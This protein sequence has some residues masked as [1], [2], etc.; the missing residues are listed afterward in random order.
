[1]KTHY[2]TLG[3][4][5]SASQREIRRAYLRQIVKYHP[6]RNP[7]PK[8][9]RIAAAL[10][11]AYETL[12]DAETRDAYDRKLRGDERQGLSR[13]S[14]PTPRAR[15]RKPWIAVTLRTA[16]LLCFAYLGVVMLLHFLG[17]L[18]TPTGSSLASEAVPAKSPVNAIDKTG[19]QKR[20]SQPQT[21]TPLQKPLDTDGRSELKV[22]NVT[23]A[24]A[25]VYLVELNSHRIARSFYLR[26]GDRFTERNIAPGT[27]RLAF[28]TGRDWDAKAERFDRDA[29]AGP[30][31]G[32]L[33]FAEGQLRADKT[34]GSSRYE[35]R[36]KLDGSWIED[37]SRAS[38]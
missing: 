23:G 37:E 7:D 21:G 1:M 31:A 20:A 27:Y 34:K 9:V 16:V 12:S 32:P 33:G 10:N 5:Q 3:V 8:A 4:P 24:D 19:P 11:E 28:V 38:E 18:R 35:V 13:V 15:A 14:V 6:D 2:E 25:V 30:S 29:H 17:A 36:L 22:D 26:V